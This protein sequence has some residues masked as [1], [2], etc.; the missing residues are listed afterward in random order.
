V[1]LELHSK[2]DSAIQIQSKLFYKGNVK[3]K[4][5]PPSWKQARIGWHSAPSIDRRRLSFV[6]L[7]IP[8]APVCLGA[9]RSG[10]TPAPAFPVRG[11]GKGESNSQRDPFSLAFTE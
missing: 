3:R 2:P 11:N 6:V 10:F 1:P 8:K 4:I 9:G 7:P 5:L